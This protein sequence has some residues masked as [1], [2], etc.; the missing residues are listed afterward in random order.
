MTREEHVETDRAVARVSTRVL[1]CPSLRFTSRRESILYYTA[2]GVR[3]T[4]VRPSSCLEL[5]M[6][7]RLLM[8]LCTLGRHTTGTVSGS[9]KPV[10]VTS[11]G[12][13]VVSHASLT[14][15]PGC[16]DEQQ[17]AQE[18]CQRMHVSFL[19]PREPMCL[20]ARSRVNS[21]THVSR[22]FRAAAR[23]HEGQWR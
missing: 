14:A 2:R 13:V 16:V 1:P 6:L 15:H 3:L 18:E 8:S 20:C 5:Q 9:R 10:A 19:S 11:R 12:R 17:G 21:G 4:L 7:M 23:D 22:F